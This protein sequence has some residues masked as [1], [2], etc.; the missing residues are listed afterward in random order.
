VCGRVATPLCYRH[1]GRDLPDA[2]T[3]QRKLL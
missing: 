2:G 1:L 3:G